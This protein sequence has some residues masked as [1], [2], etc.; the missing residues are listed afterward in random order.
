MNIKSI[1]LAVLVGAF[2]SEVSANG[3]CVTGVLNERAGLRVH[4]DSGIMY[5]LYA[6]VYHQV[7]SSQS[8]DGTTTWTGGFV[9]MDDFFDMFEFDYYYNKVLW[10]SGDKAVKTMVERGHIHTLGSIY[11]QLDWEVFPR[12]PGV[13]QL[14]YR[15]P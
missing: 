2:S 10:G 1:I 13:L 4:P 9:S 3:D 5:C 6:R 15:T 11:S 14:Y 8:T 7:D 12:F